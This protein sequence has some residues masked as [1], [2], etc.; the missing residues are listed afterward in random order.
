MLLTLPRRGLPLPAVQLRAVA[1]LEQR[2]AR[3]NP[4]TTTG[5]RA[6]ARVYR[7]PPLER[8]IREVDVGGGRNRIC[9]GVDRRARESF[10]ARES[11]SGKY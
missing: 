7:R 10:A 8:V 2:L 3:L 4:L 1:R 5:R 11:I 6:N 9:R